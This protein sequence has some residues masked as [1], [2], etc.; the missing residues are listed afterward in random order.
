LT[1][2]LTNRVLNKKSIRYKILVLLVVPNE[3]KILLAPS[4]KQN[5]FE[6]LNLKGVPAFFR[7]LKNEKSI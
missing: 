1:G 3:A 6:V 4:K 5:P 7:Y 2:Y